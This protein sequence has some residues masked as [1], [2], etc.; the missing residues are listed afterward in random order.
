MSDL[1]NVLFIADIIG[2]P[3]LELVQFFLPGLRKKHDIDFCIANGENGYNGLGLTEQLATQYRNLGIDVITGGNHTWNQPEFRN[4]LRNE[5]RVLR[6]LNYP[7]A[8]PGKGSI[9]VETRKGKIAVLNAQGRTFMYAIDC[10]F[11]RTKHE[12]EKL[13]QETPILLIDFHAEATAE[14]MAFAWFLDGQVSAVIGT[15]THVQTADERILPGG[16]AYITD[17]GMT[18]PHDSVIGMDTDVAIKRF[19]TQ[20]PERYRVGHGNN[21]LCGVVVRIEKESGR[22]REIERLFLP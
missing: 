3:G 22:A 17:A 5:S 18:G 6:P 10:P 7:E 16:T 1:I 12:I 13:K 4:Y 15:H 2:R 9:V 20:L 11:L 14:K 21:R 19:I 8:V